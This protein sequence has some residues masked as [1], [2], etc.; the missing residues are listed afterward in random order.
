[1]QLELFA[2]REVTVRIPWD[3][4]SPRD[5]TRVNLEGIFKAQAVKSMSDFV[6]VD[7]CDL[8]ETRQKSPR[9]YSGAPL[10]SLFP[11]RR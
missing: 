3:G 10:L 11:E 8:F 2:L 9:V 1:M 7:Q 6:S 4:R 5:L